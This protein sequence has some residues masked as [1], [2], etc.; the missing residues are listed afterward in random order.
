MP[1]IIAEQTRTGVFSLKQTTRNIT[2]D[3]R[4]V[5]SHIASHHKLPT[6]GNY[7]ALHEPLSPCTITLCPFSPADTETELPIILSPL[8]DV[9]KYFTG[10]QHLLDTEYK[11][12]TTPVTL[13]VPPGFEKLKLPFNAANLRLTPQIG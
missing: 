1:R 7:R 9:L 13:T 3:L 5:L 11:N 12:D 2:Y 10:V 4:L 6:S 8:P